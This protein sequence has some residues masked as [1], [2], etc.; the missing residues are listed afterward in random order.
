M[1]SSE[2]HDAIA[3]WRHG[4]KGLSAPDDSAAKTIADVKRELEAMIA[5]G[6]MPV[7]E[8]V[9]K[10]PEAVL[11]PAVLEDLA[12]ASEEAL[13]EDDYEGLGSRSSEADDEGEGDEEAGA[14]AAKKRRPGRPRTRPKLASPS[15]VIWV[16]LKLLYETSGYTQRQLA[17]YAKA[18]GYRLS[19]SGISRHAIQSNWVKNSKVEE[20]EQDIKSR[21]I[22]NVGDTIAKMH[23]LHVET[24]KILQNEAMMHIKVVNE[25]RK[26]DPNSLITPSALGTLAEVFMKAQ[27]MHAR[28]LGFDYYTGKTFKEK[29]QDESGEIQRMKIGV[30]TPEDEARVR[31]ASE[32]DD[33]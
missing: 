29:N 23:E 16:E 24:A 13:E 1:V 4:V 30:L 7:A 6:V 9:V 32:L 3:S 14:P 12:E 31:R 28:A 5:S 17:D 10:T 21:I 19:Q 11:I 20:I 2:P 8:P 18:K 22:G 25:R 27:N 15:A 26:I 33:D